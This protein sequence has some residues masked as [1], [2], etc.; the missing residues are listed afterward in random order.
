EDRYREV[1]GGKAVS[2]GLDD[3]IILRLTNF[4]QDVLV[5]PSILIDPETSSRMAERLVGVFRRAADEV[6][7]T[8]VSPTE[9]RAGLSTR[10][11]VPPGPSMD[12]FRDL[13]TAVDDTFEVRCRSGEEIEELTR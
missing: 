10:R 5:K 12:Y 6:A 8:G 3:G 1:W 4:G 7:R 9:L 2:L 11:S 13:L